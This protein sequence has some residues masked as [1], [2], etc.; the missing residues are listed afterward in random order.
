[1]NKRRVIA[2]AAAA[3]TFTGVSAAA[4]SATGVRSAGEPRPPRRTPP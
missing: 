1:M 2:A 3:M 4:V